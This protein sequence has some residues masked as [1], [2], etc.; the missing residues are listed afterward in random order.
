MSHLDEDNENN[1]DL[2]SICSVDGEENESSYDSNFLSYV[3]SVCDNTLGNGFK[4]YDNSLYDEDCDENQ[5]IF[6]QD[7]QKGSLHGVINPLFEEDMEFPYLVEN[8]FNTDTLS[9]YYEKSDVSYSKYECESIEEI[10]SHDINKKVFDEMVIENLLAPCKD[11]YDGH[12]NTKTNLF[13][14]CEEPFEDY[15]LVLDYDIDEIC[16]YHSNISFEY[17]PI[18]QKD[19]QFEGTSIPFPHVEYDAFIFEID[20]MHDSLNEEIFQF[21][22]NTYKHVDQNFHDVQVVEIESNFCMHCESQGLVPILLNELFKKIDLIGKID[23][24]NVSSLPHACLDE[25]QVLTEVKVV[26][27]FGGP[28]PFFLY[29][30]W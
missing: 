20:R 5:P 28:M 29:S 7:V 30:R 9:Y 13:V 22:S 19:T 23:M 18:M 10:A 3:A 8:E 17:H 16:E 6:C 24:N 26:R 4:V 21:E 11:F 2:I 14:D 27:K 12:S 1:I 15:G 25:N